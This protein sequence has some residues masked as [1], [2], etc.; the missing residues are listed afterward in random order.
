MDYIDRVKDAF[1]RNDLSIDSFNRLTNWLTGEEYKSFHGELHELI[2]SN[3]WDELEDRFY[4]IIDFGTGGRRGARGAGTNRI[5]TRTIAESAQGLAACIHDKGN[6][7]RGVVVTFDTR[8]QSREFARTVCEV[9]AGNNIPSYMYDQPRST[10]QLSFSIRHLNAQAGCMISASH[11]PPSDN[12]IKVSW[13]DG[14]QVVPPYDKEIIRHVTEVENVQSMDFD[15]AVTNGLITIAGKELDEAYL[16]TLKSLSLSNKRNARI[17]Y[18]PLHGVGATNV[19]KLLESLDFDLHTCEEQM[20][21]DPDFTTVKNHLPNPELPDAMEHVTQYAEK[22][23]ADIALAS[24]PDADRI[25]ACIPCPKWYKP[26][27]WMFLTGNQIGALI[28][29]HVVSRLKKSGRMPDHPV[30]IKTIVTTELLDAIC[31]ANKIEVISDLL[32]GFKYIAE[33]TDQLPEHKTPI[34]QTEE[35]HGYN[36]GVFV[37]DKDSAPA[38]LHLAE[39]ASELKDQNQTLF[40]KLFDLYRT[41]GLFV[42]HTRS[43][44]YHG[45]TG[46]EKMIKIM[47]KLRSHPPRA[48]GNYK[49]HH[50]IDRASN[51]IVNANGTVIGTIEQHTGNVLQFCFEASGINRLTARPSGTEPKIKF[52]AQLWKHIDSGAD[53]KTIVSL[54]NSLINEANML[55]DAI[56]SDE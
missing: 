20:T 22:I 25:G 4:T 24:D 44:F 40:D 15:K 47:E 38:A 35:S 2:D 5:N 49:L 54:Q 18:S 28:L 10:P 46:R 30:L 19:V 45:K 43:V 14:G 42:E 41:Y 8:H 53:N 34:F 23:Q 26:S 32:V 6:P 56:A 16:E 7:E 50:L 37:R 21:P 29:D 12:G 1:Q 11:N 27:G 3:S 33:V 17:A 52:Y 31:K 55:I 51:M 48:I 36:R 9:L 39:L 13:A